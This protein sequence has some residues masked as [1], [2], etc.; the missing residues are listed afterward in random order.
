M[1]TQTLRISPLALSIPNSKI[2][3]IAA[4]RP[5]IQDPI[6]LY[7]GETNLPTPDFIRQAA[8][9]AMEQG[10]LFYTPTAGYLELRTALAAE[11]GRLHG[12]SIDPESQIIVTDGG[13]LAAALALRVVL[14][15]GDEA[16][17]ISPVWPYLH[18][19]LLLC[20]AVPR[21]I[22]LVETKS[23]FRLDLHAVEAA[24]NEK[25]RVLIINSPNNP[26][27]WVA[28]RDE[29]QQVWKLCLEHN[30]VLIADEVYERLYYGEQGAT[31]PS[32][33]DL[34]DEWDHL[35]VIQSFSKTYS[36]TGWRLG[37]AVAGTRAI[38]A[39]TRV[40]EFTTT[41]ASSI[42]QRAGL[43]A[44]RD[45]ESYVCEMV[46]R[47]RAN[48]DLC[49]SLAG[50]LPHVNAWK[51][52]GAFYMLLK[53]DGLKDSLSF[54]KE[55]FRKTGVG[56]APGVGFGAG[57]EGSLRLCYA[58]ERELLR[59]AFHRLQ[60]YMESYRPGFF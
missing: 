48:R 51:P 11:I 9:K 23:G 35:I 8:V 53:V 2:R 27:G 55:V 46:G 44:L 14:D 21:Q 13:V 29:Q 34:V 19:N 6:C 40:N 31:A 45:G 47:Y 56:M 28:T 37:Y 49:Y 43:A 32:F 52:E 18:S 38:A 33:I 20:R 12:K 60:L 15:P 54:A 7:F 22:P 36:M 39:M 57:G 24:I 58:A 4:M 5:Q 1:S 50:R 30:I 25:T 16:I 41:C 59:E 26:T 42:S 17:L 10:Y 3:E